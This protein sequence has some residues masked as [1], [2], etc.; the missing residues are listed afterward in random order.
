MDNFFTSVGL[1]EELASMRIY[2]TGT[3]RSNR[4]GLPLPLKN[5]GAFR[6]APHRTLEWRMHDTWKMACIL[7][8]DK[9]PVLLLSIHALPIGFPCV[10]VSTVPRR[11]GTVQED[12]MTSSMH[13]EYTTHMRGVDVV[14]QLRASYSTQNRTHKWWHRIFFFLLDM[15]VVNMF[16]IYLAECKRRLQKPVSH[17]QFWVKLCETLVHGWEPQRHPARPLSRNFCYPVF[18]GLK[19]LCVVCNSSGVLPVIRPKTYCA[20]CNKY[21]CFK[22]GCYKEYHESL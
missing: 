5:R 17:L 11:N 8:K 1:F 13:L 4:I 10:H 20:R 9:K 6:N 7:W 12:I 19:A 15:T 2:A 22:K 16:I 14:D 18:M 21:M 3:V